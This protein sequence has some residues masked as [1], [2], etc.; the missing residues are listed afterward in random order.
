MASTWTIAEV[1]V[2][3]IRWDVRL[4]LEGGGGITRM[5]GREAGGRQ[6]GGG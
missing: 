4:A 5:G 1:A 2:V 6:A 3:P